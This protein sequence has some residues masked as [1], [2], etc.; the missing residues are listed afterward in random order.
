ME[1]LQGD[2]SKAMSRSVD[3]MSDASYA[4]LCEPTQFSGNFCVDEEYLRERHGISDFTSYNYGSAEDLVQD[5]FLPP[6]FDE[7]TIKQ[8]Y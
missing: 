6:R 3:I 5:I 4:I 2:E 1:M 8:V 7:N